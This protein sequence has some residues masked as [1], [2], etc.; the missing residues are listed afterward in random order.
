MGSYSHAR[1]IDTL[2]A[3]AAAQV[4][5]LKY[6]GSEANPHGATSP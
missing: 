2:F 3:V 6:P 1:I 5:I 4:Y